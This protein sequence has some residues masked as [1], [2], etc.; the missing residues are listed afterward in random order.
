MNRHPASKPDQRESGIVQRMRKSVRDL[1]VEHPHVLLACSGGKDSVALAWI[2]AELRRLEMLTFSIAHIHHGQ[3]NR[4]DHAADAVREVGKILGVAVTV[5]RLNQ[6]E[7]DAHV[8][9]GLEEAMRRERY[10]A[11][12]NIAAEHK[13]DCIALAHH[14]T[15]QAETI[16]LHLMRGAGVNG[17]AG[18]QQWETRQVPWWDHASDQDEVGL[19]RPLIS[20]SAEVV[21]EI[22]RT[23]GLPVVED[24]TN[25]DPAYRRNAIRHQVLPVLENIAEGSTAAIARS[26]EI[27]SADADLL[28]HLT[29][30]SLLDCLD[31]VRLSR[32]G[33]INL[34]SAMQRR[35]IRAWVRRLLPHLELSADRVHAISDAVERNRGGAKV[36]IGGG[37]TVT[38]RDGLLSI[39]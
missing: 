7:I 24:P 15:D 1:P 21:S 14:Q 28:A 17:L 16:L 37:H 32:S 35:V 10:L 5:Q 3:H 31:G 23:S 19:W 8:G 13:A 26:A 30:R 25:I 39:D 27:I 9:V 34:S 18:M 33:L 11:L 22:A 2:L 4:A 12:A 36:Q 38:L 29:H 6:S 20:E